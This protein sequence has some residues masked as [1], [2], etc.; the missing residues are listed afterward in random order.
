[1]LHSGKDGGAR[2]LTVSSGSGCAPPG[3]AATA[4]AC[5]FRLLPVSTPH[6]AAPASQA[7]TW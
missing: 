1:M 6:F 7:T 3:C 2:V 4:A 5:H